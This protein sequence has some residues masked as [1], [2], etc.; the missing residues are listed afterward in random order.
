[1]LGTLGGL[2]GMVG[3]GGLMYLKIRMDKA[4]ATPRSLGMDVAFLV[5]LF[6][7][8]FTGLILL[9]FRE[10]P[11]MG[12]L[13]AVHLGFVLGLFLTLPSSKFVHAI[14]R[15]ASLLNNAVELSRERDMD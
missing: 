3:T 4:P 1:M 2:A 11:A 7:V 12:P 6:L 15:Y 13:L 9:I 8:N 14:Y 5:V 10:T